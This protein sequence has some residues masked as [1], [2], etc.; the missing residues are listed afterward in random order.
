L[1]GPLAESLLPLVQPP[2][3]T[4]ITS[5][6][7]ALTPCAGHTSYTWSGDDPYDIVR[8]PVA[9]EVAV[10]GAPTISRCCRMTRATTS[11]PTRATTTNS[12]T[13]TT[14]RLRILRIRAMHLT[15]GRPWR[16]DMAIGQPLTVLEQERH[17]TLTNGLWEA[18]KSAT[19]L[20]IPATGALWFTSSGL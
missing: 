8:M 17:D 5:G 14:R 19:D 11:R 3:W 18:E 9:T 2:P 4:N 6:A 20:E 13:T 10:A 7:G 15:V 12:V 16:P 1:Y